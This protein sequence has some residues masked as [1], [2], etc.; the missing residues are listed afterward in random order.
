[1]TGTVGHF[2]GIQGLGKCS[3]LVYLNQNRIG[4]IQLNT[5]FQVLY[6]GHKKVVAH[7]LALVANGFIQQYP[8]IPVAFIATIF[9]AVDGE[10]LNEFGK[11]GHLL[12][13][14]ALNTGCA[15]KLRIIVDSVLIEFRSCAVQGNGPLTAISKP[16]GFIPA[17]SIALMMLLS[18]SSVP[19][20]AGAK[21]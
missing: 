20:R 12:L 19:S 21:P 7:Q 14:T 9:N 6:V 4:R 2:N 5:F 13:A 3:N 10:F 16:P 18:A 11:E 17:A 15:F 8:T 1:M